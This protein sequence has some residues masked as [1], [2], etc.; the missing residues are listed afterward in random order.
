[1]GKSK[2]NLEFTLRFEK[3]FFHILQALENIFMAKKWEKDFKEDLKCLA[4]SPYQFKQNAFF[5]HPRVRDCYFKEYIIPYK[6]DKRNERLL[7][8]GIF[9]N[10]Y[11]ITFKE[12]K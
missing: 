4:D 3:D 12:N 11:L 9:K 8:M 6:I 5:K 1:M 10:P 7:I 2:M